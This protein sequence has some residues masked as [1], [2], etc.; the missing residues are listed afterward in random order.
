MVKNFLIRLIGLYRKYLSPLKGRPCCRFYPSCSQYAIDA[1][2]EWG[3]IRGLGLSVWRILRCNP[4]CRGGI[5]EVP[6]NRKRHREAVCFRIHRRPA[7]YTAGGY[8]F[9]LYREAVTEKKDP[10]G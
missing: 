7:F 9:D 3:V 10:R 4:F 5:D 1:L 8:L 6:K 2:S